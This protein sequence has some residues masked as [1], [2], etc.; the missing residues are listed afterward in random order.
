MK[1]K[2]GQCGVDKETAKSMMKKRLCDFEKAMKEFTCY[3]LIQLLRVTWFI[4]G[5]YNTDF[6]WH[7]TGII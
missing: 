2:L 7:I 6:L 1:I 5:Q 4:T 3:K